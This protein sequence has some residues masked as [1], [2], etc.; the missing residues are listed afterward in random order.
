M[1]F[2]FSL[3]NNQGI[4]DV[5]AIFRLAARAEELGFDSVWA[6]DHVFNVSYVYE[7]LGNRPY[8]DPLSILSYVAAITENLVLGTSVLVLPYHNPIRL[9]KAAATLDVM[10]GGRLALGVGVGVIEQELNALGSPFHQRG[11]I[12]NECIAIMKE[13]WTQEDP[14]FDGEFYSFSGMK[15]SPKPVQKPH[16]PLLIGGTSRAAIRRAASLGDG[17]HPTAMPPEELA[18]NIQ[19]LRRQAQAAGRD[20]AEIAVSISVP[21]QGGRAGRFSLGT[22]PEEIGP[23]VEAFANLGVERMVISPYSDDPQEMLAAAEMV[24]QHV[25]PHFS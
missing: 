5:Q 4:E 3:S 6:S 7:R 14:S 23:K 15:F 9:A 25:I 21:M 2:G 8:Y 20:A 17:W 1:K 13:L 18:E 12:T 24:G 16:I 22:D 10:S 19:Y 11:A